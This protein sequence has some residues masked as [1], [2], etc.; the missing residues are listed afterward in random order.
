MGLVGWIA[1]N[2]GIDSNVYIDDTFSASLA[3]D[4]SYYE[5]YK[6]FLPTPQTETLRLWDEITLNHEAPKQ[7]WGALLTVIGFEVDPNAMTFT[8]PDSKRAELLAA[9]E[10]FCHIPAGGRRHPLRKFQQ[11]AGWINWAL[12]VYPLL[13]PALSHVYAKMEGKS[14]SD[15]AIFVNRGVISDLTWFSR[16]VANSTGIHLLESLDWDPADADVTAYCDASLEGLGVYFPLAGLG[17]QSKPP[18]AAP[19]GLIF[20]FEA[21]CVAWCLHIIADLA[22]ASGRVNIRRITIWTDNSN[23]YNIFNS[24]R[25]LPLY[26]EILKSSVDILIANGFK[27][28]VLLLPG[29][30]NVV[31]DA[32]SRWRNDVALLNH[33]DLVIDGSKALPTIPYKPPRDALG[34]A[35]K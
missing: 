23:T 33:P 34:A 15:A 18:A 7:L 26:N 30:A 29:K 10:E 3:H 17:Y 35:E 25:A 6:A 20:Y 27:L 19:D 32:L 22:R 14:A 2:R 24:L 5:P 8:M 13:K 4:I 1:N 21:F 28:Q 31:A 16:H 11:L 9:V 12:N